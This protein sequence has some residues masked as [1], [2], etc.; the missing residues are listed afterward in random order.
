[1]GVAHR[2][3]EFWYLMKARLALFT[4]R[5]DSARTALKHVIRRNPNSFM[6]HFVLGR[7]YWRERS[8]VK[9]KREFDLAWQIDPERFERSYARL[10]D[11]QESAPE[12]FSDASLDEEQISVYAHVSSAGRLGDFRDEAE[13]RHFEAKPPITRDEIRSIDWDRFQSEIYGEGESR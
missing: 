10:R 4:G 12:L 1:M 9:A 6:A 5:R 7:L 2:F 3:A 11:Q 8:V 13:R